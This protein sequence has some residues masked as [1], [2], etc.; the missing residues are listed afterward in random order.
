MRFNAKQT[1]DEVAVAKESFAE[2]PEDENEDEFED[3]VD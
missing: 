2:L 3:G 1:R